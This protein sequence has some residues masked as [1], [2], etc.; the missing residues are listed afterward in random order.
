[1]TPYVDIHTHRYT[2]RCIEL[3]ASGVHP[4]RA[5]ASDWPDALP[6]ALFAGAQAVGETGLDRACGVPL[7]AQE[8]LFRLHLDA[9]ARLSLPVVLHCVRAFEPVMDILRQYRLRAVV[10]H[11]FIGSAQQAARALER[12]YYLSFGMSAMRSPRTVEAMRSCPSGRIFAETDDTGGD[13]AD[14]YAMICDVRGEAL[15]A[16]RERMLENYRDIFERNENS[17]EQ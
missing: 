15:E 6:D 16:L 8:R 14:V 4:W 5:G 17:A 10:F 3:R 11:G 12:G 2:G 13:I 1:M 7:E 9:A